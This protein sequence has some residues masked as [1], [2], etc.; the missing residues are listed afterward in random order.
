[1]STFT[2]KKRR[3][4]MPKIENADDCL[5]VSHQPER[6]RWH[7][8]IRKTN[9]LGVVESVLHI[10]DKIARHHTGETGNFLARWKLRAESEELFAQGFDR[11]NQLEIFVLHFRHGRVCF[12]AAYPPASVRNR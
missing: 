7:P 5:S 2:F 6:V 1:M 3:E 9:T 8:T 10:N 12:M 4:R 11:L